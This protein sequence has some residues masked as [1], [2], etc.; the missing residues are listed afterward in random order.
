MLRGASMPLSSSVALCPRSVTTASPNDTTG[1]LC[2]S[3]KS[4]LEL[5]DHA[6]IEGLE[7]N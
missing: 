5:F 3:L 6:L 7:A 4:E 1:C 2:R